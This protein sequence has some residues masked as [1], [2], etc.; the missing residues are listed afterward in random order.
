M[1]GTAS[2]QT[3]TSDGPY[4]KGKPSTP[5]WSIQTMTP[6]PRSSS[7]DRQGPHSSV[8]QPR[9]PCH[10]SPFLCLLCLTVLLTGC[11]STRVEYFVDPPYP[12][13][14]PKSQVEWL[15]TEP[16]RPHIDLALITAG[17]ANLSEDTLRRKIIERAR[18]LGADAVVAEGIAL[19]HSLPNPPYYERSLFGPMGAGFGLY[20]YGWYTPY[21]SNPFLLTQG[22]T[23][24]PRTDR[25]ISGVA[26]RYKEERTTEPLP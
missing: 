11:A 15:S 18:S 8:R 7:H 13:H 1:V 2:S 22:A 16:R 9:S 12:P 3:S 5:M 19:V 10:S 25:Y 6:P 20:G 23:D 26:I 21:T 14:D 4:Q 17:S 24:I